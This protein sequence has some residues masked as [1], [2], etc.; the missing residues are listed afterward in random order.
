MFKFILFAVA[1]FAI[2]KLFLGDQ[3]KRVQQQ[4]KEQEEKVADGVMIEDPICGTYVATDSSIRVK[5]GNTVHCFC[6]YECR[7]KYLEHLEK[8]TEKTN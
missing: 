2:Y 1:A 8:D 4:A 6:S 7:D 5:Q 3:K